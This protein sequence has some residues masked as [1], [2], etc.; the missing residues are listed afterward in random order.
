MLEAGGTLGV[1]R[2]PSAPPKK[3]GFVATNGRVHAELM[4]RLTAALV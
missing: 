3:Q 1:I 4:G 2:D